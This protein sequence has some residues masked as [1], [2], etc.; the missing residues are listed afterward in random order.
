MPPRPDFADCPRLATCM[1]GCLD[2]IE[3]FSWLDKALIDCFW[4]PP[5]IPPPPPICSGAKRLQ[6]IGYRSVSVPDEPTTLLSRWM[7][8]RKTPSLKSMKVFWRPVGEHDHPALN[9]HANVTHE[10]VF[11]I[12]TTTPS[13]I[14]L[15]IAVV[16]PVSSVKT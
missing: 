8:F 14:S 9:T 12:D 13:V 7:L 4:P 1:T 5:K 3:A 2:D 16:N 11:E 10:K 6:G 15:R